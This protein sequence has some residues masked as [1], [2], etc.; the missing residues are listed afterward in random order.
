MACTIFIH[1]VNKSVAEIQF[2]AAMNSAKE[3]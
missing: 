3:R 1:L 2:V